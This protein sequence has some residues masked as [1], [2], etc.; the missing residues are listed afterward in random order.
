[1]YTYINTNISYAV[2][3]M[4]VDIQDTGIHGLR[5]RGYL[6]E[7]MANGMMKPSLLLLL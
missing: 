5:Q 7:G 3:S 4:S 2:I 6:H 1:M